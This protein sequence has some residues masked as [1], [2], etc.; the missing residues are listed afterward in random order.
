MKLYPHQQ[1]TLEQLK[2]FPNMGIFHDM[3][4]GKTFTGSEALIRYGNRVNLVICQKSKVEDWYYHFLENYPDVV[5]KNLTNKLDLLDFNKG[6]FFYTTVGVI[7]YELVWRRKELLKLQDFTLILDESSLIQNPNA[8]RTKFILKMNPDHVILL[9]GSPV[10]GKYENLWSQCH[11]LGWNISLHAYEQTYV[12]WDRIQVGDTY[13]RIVKKDDPY[14]NVDRLKAKMKKHGAVFLKTEEVI[15][16]PQQQFTTVYC[17]Q[18]KEYQLFRKH[19]SVVVEGE[20]LSADTSLTKLLYAR[21]LCSQYNQNKLDSFRD[22]VQST[23][24]RLVV[25]YNFDREL[26][27]LKKIC[28]EEGRPVSQINGHVKDLQAYKECSDSVTLIQYQAGSMGINL[29]L[30]NTIIYFSLP[31]SSEYFEQSKKRIHRIGQRNRC[32]YYVMVCRHSVEEQIYSTLKQ[33]KDFT[34]A[35]FI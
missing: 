10:G 9:S 32:L 16:L 17:K 24:N 8:K 6:N 2:G 34:D 33:R 23:G 4:L 30:S 7:N 19:G 29:Q 14:K 27:E 20:E 15:Q 12:N 18:T 26:K 25:F 5:V 3:G 28:L 21:Q 11:L 22:L 1:Q 31:L 35:L 13:H